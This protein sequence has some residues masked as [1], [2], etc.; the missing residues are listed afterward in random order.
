[1]ASISEAFALA[2]QHHQAGR[3]Q[4]AE[5]IYRQIL[6]AEPN[7]AEAI[8]LLGVLAHQVGQH[9]I[10]V[11]TIQRAI[12]LKGNAFAFH[13]NLGE[14]YRALGRIPEAVACYRR[15]L[16]L[17]PDY[18]EAHNNLGLALQE[19][20]K[21]DEAVACYRRALELKPDFA[22][23]HYNLGISLKDR[24]KLDEAVA[25][26]RRALELKPDYAEAHNNLGNALKD[27][28]KLNEAVA[29]FRRALELKSAFVE[30]HYN[31]GNALKDQ[32]KL[33]EAIAGYRRALELKPEYAEAHNNLGVA[34]RDQELPDEAVACYR[35]ALELKPDFAEAHYNLGNALKDQ[36]KLDEAVAG[37]RRALELKP[38]Y[39]EAHNNLGNAWKEQGQLDEAAACF[40]RALKLKPDYAEA[41]YNLGNALENR[42][43]L[44]EAVACYRQALELKPNYAEAHINLGNALKD[45]GNLDDAVACYHRALELKPDFAEAHSN[46][47]N[48]LKDQG[49]VDEAVAC[50]RRALEFKPDFAPGHS[51]LVYALHFD[52]ESNPAMLGQEH[53]QW[54]LRHAQ[55]L[56]HAIQPHGNDPSP[57]RRLR[58]GYVSPDFRDH[59]ES[60]FTV[61][62][63]SAHDHRNFEIFCYADIACPDEVTARL[64]GY[65]DVWRNINGLS[66]EQVTHWIR[67]DQIDILVDLTMHMAHNRLLAFARKPA[68]VQVTWLAYQGTTGMAAIDYR[69]TD[70]NIDPPGLDDGH[71]SEES[72]RLPDAFWCYDPCTSEATVNPLP[73]LKHG[74]I[75]FGSF[76]N[77]CKINPPVLKLWADVLRTTANS[78]LVMLAAAGSPQRQ[79]LSVL[80]R[81][82]IAANRVEFVPRCPRPRYLDYY[83]RIDIGLDTFPYNGQTT[84]LDAWWMGVPVVTI[85]GNTAV[86]RSGL[87]LARNLGTPEW[88]ADSPE[89]FVKIAATLAG[90]MRGLAALRFSLR[91]R[92]QRSPLM[93]A[94]RF[95]RNMESA[96]REMWRRWCEKEN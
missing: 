7:H 40:C 48:A 84:T 86:A 55:P 54:N 5:Q 93:D 96:Y 63:L 67:Q 17:K 20:G 27:Q 59:A 65:A 14:A 64:R 11:E 79:T 52:P 56:A 33:G 71:Y 80:E 95:A 32:G 91:N 4:A 50:Y 36:G 76:N 2:I 66:D 47:G 62:L 87:S 23:A 78:R 28:G 37:Y 41:H 25:C 77:F 61:P 12:R 3:L 45:Q 75:T 8:H 51:N 85:A 26:Y 60:F 88:I 42:G 92:L 34:F 22:E 43:K 70:P 10:A 89:Q 90:D 72:I 82:G 31:L 1:M 39:A 73:A 9:G 19:Q 21:L 6:Q 46:L 49:K 58:V 18:A 83:H 74:Y 30:A 57:D 44:D 24:G 38:E 15:A 94:P 68:P 53:H 13:N 81:E 69:I 35:R 29:C 16:E